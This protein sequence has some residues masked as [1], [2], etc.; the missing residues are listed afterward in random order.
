MSLDY[1]KLNNLHGTNLTGKNFVV[2]VDKLPLL[3][4]NKITEL[5]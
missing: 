3:S 2:V 4:V 1:V 5:C